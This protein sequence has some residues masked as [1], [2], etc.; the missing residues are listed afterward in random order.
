MSFELV[1]GQEERLLPWA[2]ERIEVDGFRND[3]YAIGLERAGQLIAVVVFENY[4]QC[5]VWMSVAADSTYWANPRFLA[6]VFSYPF[7]QLGLRRVTSTVAG[8]NMKSLEF[9][10]RLGFV[11][12]GTCRN[13]L[14][15]DDLIFLGLLRE[16]C[17]YLPKG[18]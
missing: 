5:D 18:S 12:E 6:A 9:C 3:A 4:S 8:K 14:P 17:R 1:Y 2:A 15:D 16:E 13:A 7:K 10:K 11:L